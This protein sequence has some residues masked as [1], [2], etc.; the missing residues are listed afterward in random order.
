MSDVDDEQLE[1]YLRK[2][3]GERFRVEPFCVA[4]AK[5]KACRF[6]FAP[7]PRVLLCFDALLLF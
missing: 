1:A 5:T 7:P 3:D 6:L 4:S 2:K